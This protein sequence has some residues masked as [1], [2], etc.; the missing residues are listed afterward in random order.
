MKAL[1]KTLMLVFLFVSLFLLISCNEEEKEN[2]NNN[3]KEPNTDIDG[4]TLPAIKDEYKVQLH[5]N[6]TEYSD[7]IPCG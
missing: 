3:Q 6:K 7:A 4:N 1:K 5:N 2:N